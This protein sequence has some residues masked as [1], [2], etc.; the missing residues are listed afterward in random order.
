M[1]LAV[2][3][4]CVD[5]DRTVAGKLPTVPA[6]IQQCFNKGVGA[7]PARALNIAEVESLWKNDRVRVVVMQTCGKRVLS[8]YETLRVNWK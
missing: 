6:D 8:W 4:G 1:L 3:G 5:G 2:L 7:V